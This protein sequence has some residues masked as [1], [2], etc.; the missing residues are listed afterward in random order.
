MLNNLVFLKLCSVVVASQARVWI[1]LF[2]YATTNDTALTL[3]QINWYLLI[4]TVTVMWGTRTSDASSDVH[5]CT[6]STR[7]EA[8]EAVAATVTTTT[9]KVNFSYCVLLPTQSQ[10]NPPLMN[11]YLINRSDPWCRRRRVQPLRAELKY[12]HIYL[13]LKRSRS[14]VQPLS[15]ELALSR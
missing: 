8:A 13:G 3:I 9:R 2:H 15:A 14:T 10:R 4:A 11:T 7:V 5:K 1:A 6:I 12:N